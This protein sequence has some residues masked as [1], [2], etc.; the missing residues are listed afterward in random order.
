MNLPNPNISINNATAIAW[1]EFLKTPS[2]KELIEIMKANRPALMRPGDN[3]TFEARAIRS[4]ET[5]TWE[6]CVDFLVSLASVRSTPK[7]D[8]LVLEGEL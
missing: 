3:L 5:Q 1:M 4:S 7:N 8:P 2:G 6:N